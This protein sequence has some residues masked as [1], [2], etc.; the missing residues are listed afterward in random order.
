MMLS[1]YLSSSMRFSEGRGFATDNRCSMALCLSP[2]VLCLILSQQKRKIK[3]HVQCIK[4]S[5]VH[6]LVV[7]VDVRYVAVL[8]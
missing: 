1:K 4:L 5:F 6:K 8:S 3:I 2:R 7:R